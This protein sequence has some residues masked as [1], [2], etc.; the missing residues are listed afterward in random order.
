MADE[1]SWRH[2]GEGGDK[3][4]EEEVD[5]TVSSHT[6]QLFNLNLNDSGVQNGQRRR[7]IRC[8]GQ[9][10]DAHASTHQRLQGNRQRYTCIS[11]LEVRICVDATAYHIEPKR[12]DGC[13]ALWNQGI[14]IQR[15]RGRVNFVSTLLS[16]CGFTDTRCER[17]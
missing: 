14:K 15:R 8:R 3:E 12:H 1:N 17:R 9:P 4:E 5:E 13:A 2:D 6:A 10:L 7:F 16:S 11:C